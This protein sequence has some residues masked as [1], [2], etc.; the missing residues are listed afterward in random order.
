MEHWW[1]TLPLRLKSILLRRRAERELEEELQFH[2]EHKI[3][4][5]IAQGLTPKEARYRALR[6]MDGL[7]QRKEEIRDVRHVRWLTDFVDD[8][9]YAMRSLRRT[10]GLTAFVVMTLAL[11]IGMTATPFSML[12]AL[13]FRPYPVANPS[14][15]LTL[16]STSRDN[17]FDAFSHGEY[18]DIR[19]HAESYEGVTASLPLSAVGFSA[20]AD[21]TPV[22]RGGMLVSGNY[23]RVLGVEP[24]LG[25]GFR[26][27]EDTVPGRDAVVVLAPG[28]WK[29]E[30][31]SDPAVVGRTVRLNGAEF[32]VIGVAPESFPGMLIFSRPDFYVPLAMAKL[33]PTD[34]RK[35]FFLDRDDRALTVRARLKHGVPQQQ[36]QQ[37]MDLLAKGFEREYPKFNRD[38]GAAVR[39]Q[40]ELRTRE[41]DVNWKFSV[42]F[43]VLALGVLLVACTNAAG[44]LLSRARTRTREIAVRLA[45]G[46]GRFRLIR[47]LLTESLV[48]SFLGGLGGIGVGYIGIELLKRFEIPADLPVTVP[49]RMDTR[50][51]LASLAMAG[52]CALFC[53]L[54]P[55]LQST[56]MD[57]SAGLKTADVDVPGRKRLW[58]RNALVVAQV[59]TSLML[60]A[61]SFLMVRGF[62]SGL[63][64]GI[65]FSKDHLLM[66]KFDPRLIQYSE[67]QTQQF[68]RLLSERL[69]G[70]AGVRSTGLTQ[71][72]PLGLDNFD[73]LAF[74]PD[75]F[76]MPRDRESFT[77]SMDTVDAGYFQTMGIGIAR[78]RGLVESDSAEAP[79]VA[80]V[81][82]HFAK[83]Y[84]PNQDALGQHFRLEGRTGARVRIVGI[85][86]T[87]KYGETFEKPRDFVYLPMAQR[88]AGR[89]V[90]MVKTTGD[91]MQL[92]QPVK[93]VVRGLDPNMPMIE[94]RTYEDLYRYASVDGP[95]VAINLV[96]TFGAVGLLLAMA[97]LY[98]MVAY[99]VSRRTREIGIRMAIGANQMDVLRLMMG[100]GLVL[101]GIGTGIGLVLGFAVERMLNSMLF[102]AGGV[103]V[104]A[105]LVVAPVMLLVTTLAAY[106]PARSATRIAPTR[107]LRYE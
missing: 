97:G 9:R 42:I 70:T 13:I 84:W 14:E 66:V 81:N 59:A 91:P 21:T 58:G 94:T 88:A 2:L 3:E 26:D 16:M 11:G 56:R 103:D 30:F 57:L 92:V 10:P 41:D 39:T 65:G 8:V 100:K 15:I 7:E 44:L 85:A 27:E 52:L 31:A 32:T 99:N 19:T 68:Y 24:Q 60:L 40:F 33:F 43:T 61:A 67:A 105:Y 20:Q 82:E 18:L 46:A 86:Q 71:N 76:E 29:R 107:A 49:F 12:D 96:G 25:R 106:V 28:F 45:M 6:A 69:R 77:T 50:V 83:H 93:D 78:G 73:K 89:M 4:E 87:V 47:L 64:E 80:V 34:P 63:V 62:R 72:P 35:S 23:F 79:R 17:R 38:R 55:A 74:V 1:Y 104:L 98:G 37:E 54:A 75:G 22:V 53:G 36:A 5:G 95:Q 90:L 101:V 51:L 48:I 102:N